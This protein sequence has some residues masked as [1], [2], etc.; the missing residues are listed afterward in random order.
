MDMCI[1]SKD[2][3]EDPA[4]VQ[5]QAGGSWPCTEQEITRISFPP[6]TPVS[7]TTEILSFA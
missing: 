4:S 2:R 3:K 5:I 1:K 6:K 7:S